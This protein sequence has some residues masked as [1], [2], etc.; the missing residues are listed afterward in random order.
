MLLAV[1]D[2][3]A[4]ADFCALAICNPYALSY[5]LTVPQR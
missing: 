4:Q 1:P 2:P 5:V 3:T